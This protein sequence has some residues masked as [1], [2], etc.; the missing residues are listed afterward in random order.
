VIP[1]ARGG[2]ATVENLRLVCSARDRYAAELTFGVEF[3]SRQR[4][5]SRRARSRRLTGF[6]A[7]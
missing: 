7:R 6:R 5:E 2:E 4:E 1:V 3:T